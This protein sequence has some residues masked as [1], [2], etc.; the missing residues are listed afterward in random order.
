MASHTI[1]PEVLL[2]EINK[3]VLLHRLEY[4]SKEENTHS[5]FTVFGGGR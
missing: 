3:C 5:C 4:D 2:C 1:P